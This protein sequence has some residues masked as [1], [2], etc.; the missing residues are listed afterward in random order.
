MQAD[1]A[2]IAAHFPALIA[3]QPIRHAPEGLICSPRVDPEG[4]R[5]AIARCPLP[6]RELDTVPGWPDPPAARVAGWYRRAP[7]HATAPPGVR[8]LV[9]TPGE[10]FGPLGHATTAM[11]L[12]MFAHMPTGPA[13]D[14]GCGSGLLAQAWAAA[15]RGP[16][17]GCDLD[18]RA[19]TQARAGIASAGLGA[20]VRLERR[21]LERLTPDEL[22]GRVLLANVP[23]GA[24]RTLL[25]TIGRPPRAAVLSGLRPDETPPIIVG[26]AGHGLTVVRSACAGGF[27]ALALRGPR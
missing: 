7:G 26:W 22:S 12:A 5:A 18:G 15:G 25:G 6:L 19:V 11:C 1:P 20:Q 10:G 17:D 8:E 9:Q 27:I 14:A 2:T 3:L 13:F 4:A 21:S 23:A 16:V 24:H